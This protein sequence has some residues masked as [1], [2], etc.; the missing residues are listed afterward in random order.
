MKRLSI[1]VWALGIWWCSFCSAEEAPVAGTEIVHPVDGALMV[2]VPA[3]SFI[4]GLNQDEATTIARQLGYTNSD[5]LWM[6]ECLPK[7]Q[8]YTGGYFIDKY[9][10]STERWVKFIKATP[11]FK[12][13]L[14]EISSYYSDP[15]AQAMPVASIAW[16]EAQ[17]YA[18]WAGKQLPSEKQWEKAARGTD[19]RFYPWGNTFIPDI[20][21]FSPDEKGGWDHKRIYTR[22][23]KYPKG[24]SPYGVMDMLGNQYEWTSEW[25]EPYPNNPQRDKMRAYTAHQN[26]CLRGGSWYHGKAS[27][28]AAKRFGLPPE[29]TYYH[30][31]FRTVW[32]P[33]EGYF[34]SAEY[35]EA[36]RQVEPCKKRIL[37]SF[38][39]YDVADQKDAEHSEIKR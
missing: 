30:I 32:E 26:A 14:D 3:G 31:G 12:L 34:D 19:G 2:Y 13:K 18:N 11:D 9:E 20:G 38:Q 39:I 33:P 10:V 17:R 7:R 35:K 27:L 15:R 4:M 16:N 21:H 5:T 28:Y 8:E 24:A 29:N 6:W 22:A 23:G 36:V 37:E 1:F 25:V